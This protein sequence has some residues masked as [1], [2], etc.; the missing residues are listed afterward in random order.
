MWARSF[1]RITASGVQA[2]LLLFFRDVS[3]IVSARTPAVH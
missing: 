2:A 3:L 1:A